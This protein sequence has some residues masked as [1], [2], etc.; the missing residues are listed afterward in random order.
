MLNSF[1]L[2]IYFLFYFDSLKKYFN[3][4][5]KEIPYFYNKNLLIYIYYSC[6]KKANYNTLII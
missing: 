4:L 1:Y 6:L 5:Q 3:Q 2:H